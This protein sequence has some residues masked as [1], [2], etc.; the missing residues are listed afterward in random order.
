MLDRKTQVRL[1]KYELD[2]IRYFNNMEKELQ[3]IFGHVEFI[4]NL[5][6][7]DFVLLYHVLDDMGI[8]PD[9]SETPRDDYNNLYSDL[10]WKKSVSTKDINNFLDNI[11]SIFK[12]KEK[13]KWRNIL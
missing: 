11:L 1:L 5:P 13:Q 9:C 8:P 10:Y 3:K 12:K 7:N 6:S 2:H 4:V